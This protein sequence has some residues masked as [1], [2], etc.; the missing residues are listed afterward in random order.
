MPRKEDLTK[1][2]QLGVMRGLSQNKKDRKSRTT[3]AA[4]P[5]KTYM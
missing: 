3:A 5:D 2:V 4:S 1:A